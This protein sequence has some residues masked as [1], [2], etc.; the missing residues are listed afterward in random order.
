MT[1]DTSIFLSEI[2][3]EDK[4][5]T[6][7]L[8]SS[9]HIPHSSIS[10]AMALQGLFL[11]NYGINS[12]STLSLRGHSSS[13]TDV[14]LD[15]FS[16]RSNMN[17]LYDFNLIPSFLVHT[18]NVAPSGSSAGATGGIGGEIRMKTD[19]ETVEGLNISFVNSWGYYKNWGEYFSLENRWKKNHISSI[20]L[21]YKRGQ[22]N[23][24]YSDLNQIG[25]PTIKMENNAFRQWGATQNHIFNI[26]KDQ[27]I[28]LKFWYANH[29]RELPPS[30][31]ESSSSSFQNDELIHGIL[32][33]EKSWNKNTF[34]KWSHRYMNEHIYFNSPLLQTDS[35]SIRYESRLE[36]KYPFKK[37]HLTHITLGYEYSQARVDD[38]ESDVA[39]EQRTYSVFKYRWNKN[40]FKTD[41]QSKIEMVNLEI[42][43]VSFSGSI[44]YVLVSDGNRILYV[45]GHLSRNHRRATFNDLYWGNS[46]FSSGNPNLESEI[47]WKENIKIKG[48]LKRNKNQYDFQ[49]DFYNSNIKNWIQWIPDNT[50]KWRPENLKAVWNRGWEGSFSTRHNL[51]EKWSMENSIHYYFTR[52][53]NVKSSSHTEGEQLIYVPFHQGEISFLLRYE[54]F[55]MNYNQNIIGKRFYTT[56]NSASLPFYSVSNIFLSY[57]WNKNKFNIKP[58]LEFKNAFNQSYQVVANRPMPPFHIQGTLIFIWK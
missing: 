29:H 25:T 56:D 20:K 12:L 11:K 48:S 32:S 26:K 43:P 13:Q 40:K 7:E 57:E 22:N 35:R 5:R 4:A 45:E 54:K 10:T 24:P 30:L 53:T 1:I 58:I 18:L 19:N 15:G 41:L 27:I 28:R 2:Q 31:T 44:K 52:S 34:L 37:Y 42:Q 36:T 14:S 46:A 51:S 39:Q 38:Y 49:L 9:Q 47:G 6:P 50:G 17:G 21:F 16:I 23:F 3:I 55:Q 33:W 8:L